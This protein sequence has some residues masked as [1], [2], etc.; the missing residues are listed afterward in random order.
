MDAWHRRPSLCCAA[1]PNKPRRLLDWSAPCACG[2]TAALRHDEPLFEEDRKGPAHGQSD[3]IDPLL[4]SL[5]DWSRMSLA[6]WPRSAALKVRQVG[7]GRIWI[8][9]DRLQVFLDH[10][11][12]RPRRTAEQ[13]AKLQV[14]LWI[15]FVVVDL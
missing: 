4:T 10:L 13:R 15:H 1:V 3:A 2:R 5:S 12:H 7:R 8:L 11:L 6:A 14:L 9:L